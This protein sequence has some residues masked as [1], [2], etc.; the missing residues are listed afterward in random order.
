MIEPF[1]CTMWTNVSDSR[2][3][4]SSDSRGCM[5]TTTLNFLTHKREAI[6]RVLVLWMR[7]CCVLEHLHGRYATPNKSPPSAFEA[8]RATRDICVIIL[9]SLLCEMCVAE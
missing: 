2:G 4:H 6:Q 5:W 8:Y 9:Y 7:P 3:S 1:M